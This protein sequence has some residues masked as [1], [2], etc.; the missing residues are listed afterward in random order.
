MTKRTTKKTC[1]FLFSF[2]MLFLFVLSC[3][4]YPIPFCACSRCDSNA[5]SAPFP[6]SSGILD[7]VRVCTISPYTFHSWS[8]G[9]PQFLFIS[10]LPAF[11]LILLLALFCMHDLLIQQFCVL[12]LSS[13]CSCLTHAS[14]WVVVQVFLVDMCSSPSLF[15]LSAHV[16]LDSGQTLDKHFGCRC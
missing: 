9:S 2:C 1:L 15:L 4:S 7:I 5:P 8:L 13:S 12:V 10:L 16:P 14:C 3:P 6:S 11:D